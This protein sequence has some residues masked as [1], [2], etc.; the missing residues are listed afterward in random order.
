MNNW[1]SIKEKGFPPENKAC[2]L[3][4]KDSGFVALGCCVYLT[5]E[6]W[7]WAISNGCIYGG[8]GEIITECEI[9]DYEFT[10]YSL[11]PKLPE[12]E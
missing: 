1:I 2:W 8:N 5:N 10:H 9:D 4:N 7:F 3:Y 12:N 6:G 11:V